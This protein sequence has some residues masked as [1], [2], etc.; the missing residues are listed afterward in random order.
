VLIEDPKI[1]LSEHKF[2]KNPSY[3]EADQLVTYASSGRENN[4]SLG[5]P[6][7]KSSNVTTRPRRL[8]L[9]KQKQNSYESHFHLSIFLYP[10]S[11]GV[12]DIKFHGVNI[13]S[14]SNFSSD[15]IP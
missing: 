9:L 11:S 12:S 5:H 7:Y 14:V 3:W 8:Q 13:R 10:D 4:L 1:L 6:D 2:F 15:L